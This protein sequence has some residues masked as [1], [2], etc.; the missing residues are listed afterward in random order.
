M[1]LREVGPADYV[2][3]TEAIQQFE[4][5]DSEVHCFIVRA[6]MEKAV[7]AVRQELSR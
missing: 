6:A 5:L 1:S 4:L 2:P 7:A 3:E